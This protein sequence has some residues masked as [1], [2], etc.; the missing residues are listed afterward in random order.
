MSL[1]I[2][3]THSDRF[4]VTLVLLTGTESWVVPRKQLGG[5]GSLFAHRKGDLREVCSIGS[6][7]TKDGTAMQPDY[8]K[9]RGLVQSFQPREECYYA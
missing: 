4:E 9:L 6:F 1:T 3:K 5:L 7:R 8:I 2:N